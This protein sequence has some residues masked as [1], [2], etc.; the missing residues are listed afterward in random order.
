MY[1]FRLLASLVF[2]LAL[3]KSSQNFECINLSG[4]GSYKFEE[5]KINGS[6]F[7]NL[8]FFFRS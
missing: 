5:T 8:N 4:T 1:N 7:Y 3:T 6:G 2:V